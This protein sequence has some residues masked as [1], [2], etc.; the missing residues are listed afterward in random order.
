VRE[1]LR[2]GALSPGHARA[3]IG[4]PD[5]V[6]L[7]LHIVDRGLNVR[8]AEALAL[9]PGTPGK[10]EPRATSPEIKALEADLSR[11]L[12][13]QVSINHGSRG[14]QLSIRY[15]D[16]DQLDGLLALLTGKMA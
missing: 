8:Q 15:K 7:A 3:L 12:G 1:L 16:L 9:R 6:A 4:T 5:P 14:G 10:P 13:L 11:H 2:D